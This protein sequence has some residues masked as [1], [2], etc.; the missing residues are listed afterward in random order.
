[1]S[2]AAGVD[3]KVVSDTLGHSKSSF[4]ADVHTS[5]VPEVAE[6]VAAIVPRRAAEAPD[7]SLCAHHVPTRVS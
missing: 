2:L 3:M 7:A 1:M 4:T 6:A 5:V